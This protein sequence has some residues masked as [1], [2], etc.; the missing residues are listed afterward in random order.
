MYC[1]IRTELFRDAFWEFSRNLLWVEIGVSYR[2]SNEY[3]RA[4]LTLVRE[5]C[6]LYPTSKAGN[7]IHDFLKNCVI[8]E[9][10]ECRKGVYKDI[11]YKILPVLWKD[12]R[13]IERKKQKKISVFSERIG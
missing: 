4:V 10:P 7:I 2:E 3:R 1:I 9:K 11:R 12:H 5:I 8:F 6:K 13:A